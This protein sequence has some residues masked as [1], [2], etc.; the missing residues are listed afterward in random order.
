MKPS[1]TV[2]TNLINYLFFEQVLSKYLVNFKPLE[3]LLTNNLSNQKVLIIYNENEEKV[4]DFNLI[5]KNILIITNK[6]IKYKINNKKIKLINKIISP[7]S[8]IEEIEENLFINNFKHKNILISDKRLKNI[9]N[10]KSCYL[11]DIEKNI[12]ECLFL[13]NS[14]SRKY[15]KQNILN[16]KSSIETNSLDSHLT[17]IR[18]KFNQI[19]A[20]LTIESKKDV[21]KIF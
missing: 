2:Y 18:K 3:D 15:I 13:N 4:V 11:T 16:I 5:S 20:G 14:T 8:I 21:I 17:R 9:I 7:Q 6:D 19:N 1:L 12:L 10:D